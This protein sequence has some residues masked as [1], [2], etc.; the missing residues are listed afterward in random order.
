M[1]LSAA[2]DR[3]SLVERLMEVLVVVRSEQPSAKFEVRT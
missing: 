2:A 3:C 1:E